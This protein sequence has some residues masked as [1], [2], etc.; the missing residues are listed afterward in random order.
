MIYWSCKYSGKGIAG[1]WVKSQQLP[2]LYASLITGLPRHNCQDARL[3]HSQLK[4]INN[5]V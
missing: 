5:F 4:V 3:Q 1:K 2:M